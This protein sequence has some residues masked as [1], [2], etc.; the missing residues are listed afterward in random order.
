MLTLQEKLL[1]SYVVHQGFAE[2]KSRYTSV[3]RSE[4]IVNFCSASGID[5]G[6]NIVQGVFSWSFHW[7]LGSEESS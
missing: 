2:G 3:P 1:G 5:S 4:V 7:A 6:R